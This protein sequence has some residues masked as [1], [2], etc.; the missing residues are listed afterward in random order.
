MGAAVVTDSTCQGNTA[1]DGGGTETRFSDP[2][3]TALVLDPAA[4]G[5]FA[6]TGNNSSSFKVFSWNG[7]IRRV[8][9][10]Q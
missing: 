2:V 9:G 4:Q 8:A 6:G 5:G 1:S 3:T 7:V 10:W